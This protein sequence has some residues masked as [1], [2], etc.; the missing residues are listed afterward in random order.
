M[1][2]VLRFCHTNDI[3]LTHHVPVYT[4]CW[5]PLPLSHQIT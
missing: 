4:P 2:L 1:T 5:T 3:R